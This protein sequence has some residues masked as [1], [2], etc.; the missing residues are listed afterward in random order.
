MPSTLREVPNVR[1]V[2][3]ERRRRWF[4]TE[5]M[6]LIVWVGE[7]GEALG[8]QLCYDKQ[9]AGFEKAFTRTPDGDTH[10]HYVDSGEAR[11]SGMKETPVLGNSA[12][13]DPDRTERL[14]V[15]ASAGLP[16]DIVEL[17]VG[18]IRGFPLR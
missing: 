16:E 13:F 8:F 11:R 10:H 6:D 15:E 7:R 14:F 1:Q 9:E 17:V 2:P 12:Y 4:A 18:M 3:G 5:H